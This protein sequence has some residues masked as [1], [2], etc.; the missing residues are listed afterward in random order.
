VERF[1]PAGSVGFGLGGPELGV[2][3]AQFAEVFGRARALGLVGV[4]HAGETTGPDTIWEAIRLL[5]ARRIG[6]GITSVQDPELVDYLATH[7]VALDIC[8]TSNVRTRAVS[9]LSEHPL[10]K[11]LRA[12][13]TVTLSSDDPGMFATTL[14]GEYEV[15]HNDLG[16]DA[17]V[18]T[19][20]ARTSARVSFAEVGLRNSILDEIDAY[21]AGAG[22]GASR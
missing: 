14:N 20:L 4:P 17:T 21:A 3:R 15:A 13:V 9:T 5:G 22:L 11:L 10:P 2:A 18:L 6:H 12:G 16:L 19:E 1:A 7:E 8:P